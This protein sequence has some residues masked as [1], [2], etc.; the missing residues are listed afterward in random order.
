[1]I[2]PYSHYQSCRTLFS[3]LKFRE[4]KIYENKIEINHYDG[5]NDL[6][7]PVKIISPLL[8]R[9]KVVILYSGASPFAEKH[10]KMQM[11]G[12]ALAK[13]GYKVFIPIK[14]NSKFAKMLAILEKSENFAFNRS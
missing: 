12:V 10:P 14:S 5:L 9:N 8:N 4:D 13:N 2:Y 1:M 3:I 6:N 11:L 7:P